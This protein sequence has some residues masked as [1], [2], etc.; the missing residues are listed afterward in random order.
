MLFIL[1]SLPAKGQNIIFKYRHLE[2]RLRYSFVDSIPVLAQKLSTIPLEK[3]ILK[4]WSKGRNA[5]YHSEYFI[6]EDFLFEALKLAKKQKDAYLIAEIEFDLAQ[7]FLITDEVSFALKY[8]LQ[9]KDVFDKKGTN[10]QKAKVNVV[11]GE[12]FRKSHDQKKAHYHLYLAKKFAIS[13]EEW[14]ARCYNRLAALKHEVH[15][16]DSAIWYTDQ[17]LIIARKINNLELI[18]VS[19]TE[20]NS[21]FESKFGYIECIKRSRNIEKLWRSIHNIRYAMDARAGQL[22][23]YGL[24]SK[25][26]NDFDKE[27]LSLALKTLEEVKGKKWYHVEWVACGIAHQIY[28]KRNEIDKALFYLNRVYEVQLKNAEQKNFNLLKISERKFKFE[29]AQKIISEQ[30]LKIENQTLKTNLIKKDQVKLSISII[31]V[32]I[33]LVLIILVVIIQ[34]KRKNKIVDQNLKLNS[35][36]KKNEALVQEIHHRVKNNLQSIS[37]IVEMQMNYEKLNSAPLN[38]VY[39]RI[40]AMKLVHEMLYQQKDVT[41][42]SISKYM[43]ELIV[44]IMEM[45]SFTDRNVVFDCDF[46]EVYLGSSKCVALG[47]LTS[48]IISNSFKHAFNSQNDLQIAIKLKC[49]DGI[50]S[51]CIKDN[52]TLDIISVKTN[53]GSRL[54][55]I[56]LQQLK[57]QFKLN[58]KEGYNYE[59]EFKN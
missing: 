49:Q 36:L 42:I 18:A 40:S 16:K 13:S 56:F 8:L 14:R 3:N 11:L 59:I 35:A 23:H 17:A 6:S 43:N 1:F 33:L 28:L 27:S 32:S 9:V 24:L 57:A 30:K 50:I 47:M 4:N 26:N 55:A 44:S 34:L 19:E 51:L 12:L 37:I 58:E 39:R 54:I 10:L 41:Q 15:E 5:F 38:D 31:A 46:D 7:S 45:S 25:D 48:E 22:Y 20:K 2:N 21:I 53:L 29:K 52:G